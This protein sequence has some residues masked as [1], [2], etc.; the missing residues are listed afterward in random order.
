MRTKL[1]VHALFDRKNEKNS[2]HF[3]FSRI[4]VEVKGLDA[5]LSV[6]GKQVELNDF[7]GKILA[8]TIVGA[9]TSLGGINKEWKEIKIEVDRKG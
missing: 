6:D 4:C 2:N 1:S 3:H 8:G 5:K 7:A 9:V